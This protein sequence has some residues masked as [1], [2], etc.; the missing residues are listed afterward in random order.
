[1]A[2]TASFIPP[3]VLQGTTTSWLPVT[4]AYPSVSGC[5]DAFFLFPGQPAPVSR[6][7][8][9]GR[10][11]KGIRSFPRVARNAFFILALQVALEVSV[12]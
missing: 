8:Y 5:A 7:F 6:I 12:D 9:K 3:E 4:T 11:D 1:M 10:D 2:V